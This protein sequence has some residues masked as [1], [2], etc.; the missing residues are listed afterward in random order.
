MTKYQNSTKP[1]EFSFTAFLFTSVLEYFSE[2][3]LKIGIL[4]MLYFK[5]IPKLKFQ[6]FLLN[7]VSQVLNYNE[8]H[9]IIYTCQESTDKL[10]SVMTESDTWFR[11]LLIL[12]W[13]SNIY[14]QCMKFQELFI[15]WSGCVF[16]YPTLT[17]KF[18]SSGLPFLSAGI[19]G[20]HHQ[21]A[22]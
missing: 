18:W 16:R 22:F 8:E 10:E 12:Y 1:L 20:M 17:S 4:K 5:S 6:H 15:C 2:N 19:T 7:T 9:F 3:S 11:L 14:C 21:A 13:N